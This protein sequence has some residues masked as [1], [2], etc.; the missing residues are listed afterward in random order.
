MV[1]SGIKKGV[2]ENQRANFIPVLHH[3]ADI[4]SLVSYKEADDA[5]IVVLDRG[6]K[7]AYQTHS[8]APG[9]GYANLRAKVESLLQ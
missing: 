3:E 4:K 7:I 2:P 8:A 5:Y 6:G 1:I 9:Q